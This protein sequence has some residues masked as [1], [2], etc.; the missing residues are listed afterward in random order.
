MQR[1]FVLVCIGNG[2]LADGSP[3]AP[4]RAVVDAAM[5]EI[6]VLAAERQTI[7]VFC[8]GYRNKRGK[9]EASAMTFYALERRECGKCG[10]LE[11]SKSYRTHN[12][13]LEV[14]KRIAP[15]MTYDSQI[16]ICDHPLH[17]SR[18]LLAFKT[19]NRLYY[20]G[21]NFQIKGLASEEVYDTEIPGQPQWTDRRT[22]AAHEKK[23]MLL[24][25]ILLSW[26]WARF[27]LWLLKT[28]WPSDKQ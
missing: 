28:V 4:S 26:P 5:K 13:A 17:L 1:R 14:M 12:N 11:E 16:T 7:V 15:H 19:V 8:G 6:T 27:G 25:R 24:Y 9:T 22:F 21:R 10:L 18:T 20:H 2:V 3:S 23:G